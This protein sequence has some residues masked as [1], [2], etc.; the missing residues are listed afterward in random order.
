MT[1][2]DTHIQDNKVFHE[3]IAVLEPKLSIQVSPD[4]VV[5]DVIQSMCENKT[6][7]ALIVQG[8]KLLGIFS[9]RDAVRKV[10]KDYKVN[11]VKPVSEFM[12]ANPSSLSIKHTIAY[13]LNL[14]ADGGYRHIPIIDD[15]NRPT[16]IISVRDI[17]RYMDYKWLN[18]AEY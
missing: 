14:M 16:G 8:D 13:A 7:A 17:I 2:K 11:A 15:Q 3:K 12:T 6:G 18:G 9:E 10:A 1:A 5:G 4:T